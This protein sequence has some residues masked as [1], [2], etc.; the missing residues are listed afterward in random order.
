MVRRQYEKIRPRGMRRML[1]AETGKSR[2]GSG[3]A[4]QLHGNKPK[5]RG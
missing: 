2:R 1:E 5:G 3:V 4:G